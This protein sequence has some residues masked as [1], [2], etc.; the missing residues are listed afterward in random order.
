MLHGYKSIYNT[1][2]FLAMTV[3]LTSENNQNLAHFYKLLPWWQFEFGHN[4]LS[5]VHCIGKKGCMVNL[6]EKTVS[7]NVNIPNC[8]AC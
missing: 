8:V 1:A 3:C 6:G 5:T 4:G 7:N 2:E